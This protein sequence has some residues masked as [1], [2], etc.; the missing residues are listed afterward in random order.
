MVFSFFCLI[1]S[2][3]TNINILQANQKV[4][5][6][7]TAAKQACI[8]AIV[9]SGENVKGLSMIDIKINTPMLKMIPMMI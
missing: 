9:G 6:I 1:W 7:G 5:A 8:C 4:V 2:D 3:K